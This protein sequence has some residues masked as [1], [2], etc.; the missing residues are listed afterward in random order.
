MVVVHHEVAKDVN[1][2]FL[3]L[4]NTVKW[5]VVCN[6]VTGT[7]PL[8]AVN[9]WMAPGKNH[10]TAILT[11][12]FDPPRLRESTCVFWKDVPV[13][14]FPKSR[15][16]RLDKQAWSSL[17]TPPPPQLL[18]S[19]WKMLNLG[20][21]GFWHTWKFQS[22]WRLRGSCPEPFNCIMSYR[23]SCINLCDMA[24]ILNLRALSCFWGEVWESF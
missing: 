2:A 6:M 17:S 14:F 11:E 20:L 16:K 10:I 15:K 22:K 5:V 12:I 18:L 21:G 24:I 3:Y 1:V 13:L 9:N 7:C 8:L 19:S 4:F 23:K